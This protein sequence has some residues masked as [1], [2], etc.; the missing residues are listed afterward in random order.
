M[1]VSIDLSFMY[2]FLRGRGEG[3]DRALR[4][5]SNSCTHLIKRQNRQATTRVQTQRKTKKSSKQ[6]ASCMAFQRCK[7]KVINPRKG[8]KEPKNKF[9]ALVPRLTRFSSLLLSTI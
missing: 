3:E 7:T 4:G 9:L 8:L 5:E 2:G 6:M 1:K